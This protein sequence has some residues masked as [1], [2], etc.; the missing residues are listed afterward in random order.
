MCWNVLLEQLYHCSAICGCWDIRLITDPDQAEEH[1]ASDINTSIQPIHA[2]GR[3][4]SSLLMKAIVVCDNKGPTHTALHAECSLSAAAFQL[5][6]SGFTP[7]TD[8][9]SGPGDILRGETWSDDG[10]RTP[11]TPWTH[12]SSLAAKPQTTACHTVLSVNTADVFWNRFFG[13]FESNMWMNRPIV[14]FAG[15]VKKLSTVH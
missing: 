14:N 4:Q 11:L 7:H 9:C 6:S 8:L 1:E 10:G 15:W 2:N 5:P 3:Q 12:C 13:Y